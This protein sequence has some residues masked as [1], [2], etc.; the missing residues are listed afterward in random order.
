[1]SDLRLQPYQDQVRTW[2]DSG[3]HVLAQYDDETIVVYQAFGPAIGSFAVKHGYFG[4]DFKLS[5]MS[6]IKPNFLWM[7]H[8][9]GW[10]T[11]PGQEVVLAIRLLRSAFDTIL[12]NAVHATYAEF[13]YGDREAWQAS[14]AGS[15]VRLQWDPDHDPQGVPLPRRA[16]QLGLRGEILRRYSREWLVD[17]LDISPFVAEQRDRLPG[18]DELVTPA[19]MVYPVRD[20]EVRRVLQVD[21]A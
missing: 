1:M 17:I 13:I 9:A 8:R 14:V 6:W 10:G 15:A 18:L 5:R 21:V 7:M 12:A 2:P 11:K 19:E 16:I 3:R 4:G 20:P